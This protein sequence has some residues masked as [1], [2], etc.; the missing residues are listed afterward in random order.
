MVVERISPN[1]RVILRRICGMPYL[2]ADM[3]R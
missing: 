2:R 1:E 3:N